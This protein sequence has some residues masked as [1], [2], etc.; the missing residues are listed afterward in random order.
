MKRGA[1]LIL[2]AVL[3]A[4]CARASSFS[5]FNAG[6][7]AWNDGHAELAIEFMTKA[8]APGDLAPPLRALA[9]LDRGLAYLKVKQPDKAVADFS[10]LLELKPGD[11]NAL[12]LRARA[13]WADDQ[14]AAAITDYK[15]YLQATHATGPAYFVLG[16][17]EWSAG[18]FADAAGDLAQAVKLSP[19]AYSVLWLELSRARAGAPDEKAF[20]QDVAALDLDDWPRPLLDYYLGKATQDDVNKAALHGD[21]KAQT[22]QKCE[23]DFYVG[24]WLL[25]HPGGMAAKPLIAD[26]ASHCPDDFIE[27]H[28]AKAELKR[29]P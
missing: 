19:N 13:N 1:F 21:A 26:A 2:L 24:E 18:R 9:Y 3:L 22:G 12:F 5:D 28:A 20:A 7:D 23:A 11:E 27:L 16:Q 6:V 29:M 10:A 17:A 14:L 8:L 15:T 4:P 25:L